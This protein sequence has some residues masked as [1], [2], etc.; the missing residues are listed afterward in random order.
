MKA[1]LVHC[2]LLLLA[3]TGCT[4]DPTTG[5]TTVEGQ[6][7]ED[8]SRKPVPGATVQLYHKQNGGYQ[9]VSV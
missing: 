7:V 8:K 5:T 2:L 9:P 3:L 1:Y 4:K 6:V